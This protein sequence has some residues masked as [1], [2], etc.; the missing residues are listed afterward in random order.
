MPRDF[1]SMTGSTLKPTLL[2]LTIKEEE[3]KPP[4]SRWRAML[5]LRGASARPWDE[6]QPKAM[7]LTS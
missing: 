5:P 2:I 7:V 4:L 6:A 1:A 3:K